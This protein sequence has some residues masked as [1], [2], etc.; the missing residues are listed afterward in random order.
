M[1]WIITRDHVNGP[2]DPKTKGAAVLTEPG[3]GC[4]VGRNPSCK[5]VTPARVA[6]YANELPT[7]FQLLDDD[8]EVYFEGRCADLG[9]Y[10]ADEAFEPLDRF[11]SYGCTTMMYRPA[12]DPTA[13]WEQL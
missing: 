10:D 13:F 5:C 2:Y 1:K 12:N 6:E 3:I 11:E 4:A 8:G 9:L 7:A